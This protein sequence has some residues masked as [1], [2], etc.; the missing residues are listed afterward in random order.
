[1][2]AADSLRLLINTAVPTVSL[3]P[4]LRDKTET[5]DIRSAWSWLAVMINCFCFAFTVNSSVHAFISRFVDFFLPLQKRCNV[6]S[7]IADKRPEK[8]NIGQAHVKS[9]ARRVSPLPTLRN[10]P[11][12]SQRHSQAMAGRTKLRASREL[13]LPSRHSRLTDVCESI[14]KSHALFLSPTALSRHTRG[15][16][17][18]LEVG[19]PP[20]A[21]SCGWP[22]RATLLLTIRSDARALQPHKTR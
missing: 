2:S 7:R 20:K 19:A 13:S 22:S 14:T 21:Q 8:P 12:S 1:M 10:R 16:A 17:A 9:R 4:C 15:T 18:T 11:G 6:I 5:V 3:A